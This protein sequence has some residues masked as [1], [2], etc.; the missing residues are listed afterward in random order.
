MQI[1]ECFEWYNT[2][3]FALFSSNL[4]KA[5]KFFAGIFGAFFKQINALQKEQKKDTLAN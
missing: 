1:L 5:W 3:H 2:W 4:V